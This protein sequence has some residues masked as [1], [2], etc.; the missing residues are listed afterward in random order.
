LATHHI[1]PPPP[2]NLGRSHALVRLRQPSSGCVG[3]TLCH[4]RYASHFSH[5]SLIFGRAF[6]SPM[7]PDHVGVLWISGGAPFRP[8]FRPQSPKTSFVSPDR[9]SCDFFSYTGRRLSF[10]FPIKL[11]SWRTKRVVSRNSRFFLSSNRF[12]SFV[13]RLLNRIECC[14]SGQAR[15]GYFLT[16]FFRD[17]LSRRD[18]AWR[19]FE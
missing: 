12:F 7:W 19:Y 3:G 1:T 18:I 11:V 14:A 6:S 5:L 13:L 2:T 4:S 10:F 9:G 15:G 17:R 16:P 8:P